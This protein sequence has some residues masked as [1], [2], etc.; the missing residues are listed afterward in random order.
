MTALF[1]TIHLGIDPGLHGAVAAVNSNGEVFGIWDAP[2]LNVDGRSKHDMPAMCRI[3]SGLA[4]MKIKVVVEASQPF[5]GS[6]CVA[7]FLL[8]KGLGLWEGILSAFKIPYELVPPQRW[9]RAMLS[10]QG[11]SKDASRFKAMK[12]FPKAELHLKKHDGRAE[13]LLMAEYGRRI[14][15]TGLV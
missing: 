15:N 8:G 7:Q 5:P 9:K 13:A 2:V 11:K 6:G 14:A 3:L 1:T 4:G 10:G 12:L